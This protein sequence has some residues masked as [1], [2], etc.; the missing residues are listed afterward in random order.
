[1]LKRVDQSCGVRDT[2]LTMGEAFKMK[3]SIHDDIINLD[4]IV[5][6]CSRSLR[7]YDRRLVDHGERVAM[8]ATKI[9]DE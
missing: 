7:L 2:S 8:I 4:Q 5:L 1:V 9:L 6:L 3:R